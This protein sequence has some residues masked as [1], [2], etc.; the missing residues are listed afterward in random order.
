[1]TFK[2]NSYSNNILY[3]G[4]KIRNLLKTDITLG[5]DTDVQKHTYKSSEEGLFASW[6][7]N[8]NKN[9]TSKFFNSTRFEQNIKPKKNKHQDVLLDF[10]IANWKREVDRTLLNLKKKR[11]KV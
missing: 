6:N 9:T 3:S 5:E 8:L 4:I 11:Y 7:K 1:M 10:K 2:I